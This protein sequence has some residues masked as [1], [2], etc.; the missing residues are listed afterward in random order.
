MIY[1]CSQ[2]HRGSIIISDIRVFSDKHVALQYKISMQ[3]KNPHST[4]RVWES[5][6]ESETFITKAVK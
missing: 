3:N 5:L 6:L 2:V 4:F 1:M